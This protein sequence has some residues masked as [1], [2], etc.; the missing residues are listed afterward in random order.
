MT[1]RGLIHTNQTIQMY[2]MAHG[3]ICYAADLQCAPDQTA[4]HR[5]Q[6]G[7]KIMLYNFKKGFFSLFF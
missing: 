6:N 2:Y 5:A 1:P 4:G 3:K 7:G